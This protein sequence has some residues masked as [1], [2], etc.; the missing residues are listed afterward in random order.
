MAIGTVA[1]LGLASAGL[2]LAKGVGGAVAAKRSFSPGQEMR[3]RELEQLR[4]TGQMGLD[5][6]ELARMQAALAAEQGAALRQAEVQGAQARQAAQASGA[7]RDLFLAEMAGA[8]AQQQVRAE[9][10]RLIAEQEALARQQQRQEM[11][12][13]QQQQAQARAG[14]AS[15]LTAG[16]VEG[17][18]AGLG[19]AAQYQLAE[20]EYTKQAEI[21]GQRLQTA[22]LSS[23][24]YTQ[25][26][27][28]AL[29]GG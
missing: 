20:L 8:E 18:Q 11:A 7:G 14:I 2:G 4:A 22:A 17:A 21:E 3:L 28:D 25:E 12:A 23:G 9:G 15:A 5:E 10:A 24:L 6:D 29:Q 27:L 1:A 19:M 13:L 16:L 26:E